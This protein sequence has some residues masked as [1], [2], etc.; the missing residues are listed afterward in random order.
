M[1]NINLSKL[2]TIL[3]LYQLLPNIPLNKQIKN[4]QSLPVIGTVPKQEILG[5]LDKDINIQK[6]FRCLKYVY[7][8]DCNLKDIQTL[9]NRITS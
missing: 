1:K 3:E 5:I 6:P 7:A 4:F 9:Y 2:T 8:I